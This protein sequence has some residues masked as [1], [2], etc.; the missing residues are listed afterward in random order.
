MEPVTIIFAAVKTAATS[1]PAIL[2]YLGFVRDTT[3]DVEKILS[4]DFNSAMS[5]LRDAY[6]TK[7]YD[8]Y[9]QNIKWALEHL[10]LAIHQ[11]ENERQVAAYIGK[12]MCLHLLGEDDLAKSIL[13]EANSVCH[14]SDTEKRKALV[15]DVVT[16]AGGI[17]YVALAYYTFKAIKHP[18]DFP[19]YSHRLSMFERCKDQIN[20]AILTLES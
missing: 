16:K 11:E 2:K 20:Q 14:L 9:V 19:F 17:D 8:L 12:S 4:K 18:E 15:S 13:K 6:E 5:F 1:T 7:D 3:N 10:T